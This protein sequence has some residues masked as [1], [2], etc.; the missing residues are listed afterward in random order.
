MINTMANGEP[1][2][3][4]IVDAEK[5]MQ[6]GPMKATRKRRLNEKTANKN[7]CNDEARAGQK[8]KKQKTTSGREVLAQYL[9]NIKAGRNLSLTTQDAISLSNEDVSQ[10]NGYQEKDSEAVSD[11]EISTNRDSHAVDGTDIRGFLIP[12]RK[13]HIMDFSKN[14]YSEN[15]WNVMH[16]IITWINYAIIDRTFHKNYAGLYLWSYDKSLGKTLLCRVISKIV[17]CYWWVFEDEGWQQDWNGKKRYDCI[18]YNALNQDS[19]SFRQVEMHGD[20]EPIAVRRRN[21]RTCGHIE[22]ETPFIITSN[23]PPEKLGYSDRDKDITVWTERMLVV[24]IDYCPIFDL[25]ERIK[26]VYNVHIKE[27]PER[28][29]LEF[30]RI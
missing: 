4:E 11:C 16:Y 6:D 26:Q 25:I 12:R 2:V 3:Y 19:L 17:N 18:I 9:S 28:P 27:E 23:V 5:N 22:P 10:S 13:P 21:Q 1:F 30:R 14:H 8:S 29:L 24:C 7:D 15:H 20:R